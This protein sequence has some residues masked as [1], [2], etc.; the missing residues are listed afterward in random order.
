MRVAAY[1][2]DQNPHRDRSLGISR[3]SET[4]LRALRAQGDAI[5]VIRSRS[6]LAFADAEQVCLPLASDR[7]LSRL[8]V[9]QLHG[10][11]PAAARLSADV[12]LYPK[13]FLPW[14]APLPSATVAVVQDVILQHYADR[15]PGYMSAA[16]NR[17]FLFALEHTLRRATAIMTISHHA[18]AQIEAFCARRGVRPPSIEVVYSA[19]D[20]G[21]APPIVGEAPFDPAGKRERVVHLA[22]PAPHK[23]TAWLLSAWQA[24]QS[25]G[26]ALPE[27]LL[28][29]SVPNAA[30]GLLERCRGVVTRPI[31]PDAE[32]RELLATARALLMPSEIEG[33]GLP[34][35]EAYVLG[36]P[37]VY[38]AETA[39]DEYMSKVSSVGR[40]VRDDVDSFEAALDAVLSLSS[41]E[42]QAT[43][44]ALHQRYNPERLGREA[45]ALLA[46]V[47]GTDPD[48]NLPR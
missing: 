47:T 18:R 12:W 35:L 32:L 33:F 45:H 16:N 40:F 23:R 36:T 17:Y 10:L 46:R 19:S 28:L 43:A 34:V 37:G 4:L 38:Q 31:A 14:L 44:A 21:A 2:A 5:T 7:T 42:V 15:Y 27:L 1:L 13:G 9:D 48:A 6:S 30:L 39:V 3:Y 20:F 11:W 29:G 25:R 22:S 41:A 8:L 26:R 24:L